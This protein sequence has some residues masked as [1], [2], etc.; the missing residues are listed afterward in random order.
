MTTITVSNLPQAS[1]ETGPANSNEN[2]DPV[3]TVSGYAAQVTCAE[4]SSGS[5][6]RQQAVRSGRRAS[7]RL[8]RDQVSNRLNSRWKSAFPHFNPGGE[9]TNAGI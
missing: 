1:G 3:M 2:T 8:L 7:R 6:I 9:F 4:L 5:P